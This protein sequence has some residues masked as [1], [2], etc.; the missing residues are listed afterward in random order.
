[1]DCS[2]RSKTALYIRSL[3]LLILILG[4]I[5]IY[6]TPTDIFP[7]INIP[8]VSIRLELLWSCIRRIWRTGSSL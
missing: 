4:P 6:R 2:T 7:N 1:M 5:V 3:A 8:V